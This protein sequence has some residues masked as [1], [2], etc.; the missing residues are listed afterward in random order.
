MADMRTPLAR[1]RGL[2][3]A[4]SGTEHF[5]IQRLTAL[6]NVPLAIFLL[7]SVVALVGADYA[8]VKTYLSMPVVSIVLLLLILSGV[9]HM[10]L[11][12]QVII[13]DY[14]HGE[15]MK[16]LSIIANNFFSALVGL[17]CVYAVLKLGLGG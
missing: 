14:V 13:E 12:M 5:W 3:S 10:R 6:A 11:G 4:K 17:A 8:T 2:G 9:Y 15:G 7:A 1:V 16:L